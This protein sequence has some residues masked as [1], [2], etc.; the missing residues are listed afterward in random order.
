MWGGVEKLPM[1]TPS[2]APLGQLTVKALGTDSVV[3][4]TFKMV[5]CSPWAYRLF[6]KGSTAV[7]CC[8]YFAPAS[9][10]TEWS[11]TG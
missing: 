9:A 11:G 10:H 3:L 7:R 5:S 4:R 8:P 6:C 1:Q 2:T